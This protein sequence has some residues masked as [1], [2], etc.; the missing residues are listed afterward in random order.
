[1]ALRCIYISLHLH[2]HWIRF[3]YITCLHT[4]I[5]DY[6]C[7]YSDCFCWVFQSNLSC[8]ILKLQLR[9]TW[10]FIPDLM[11][12]I[13]PPNLLDLNGAWLDKTFFFM[14]AS[15]HLGIGNMWSYIWGLNPP[16]RLSLLR[17]WV[18]LILSLDSLV[19]QHN[20][21]NICVSSARRIG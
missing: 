12:T 7:F 2:S 5:S 6:I 16:T 4:C 1:M 10:V 8:N 3:R 21:L 13:H 18:S 20:D 9:W 17:R 11:V 15:L 19:S 14:F